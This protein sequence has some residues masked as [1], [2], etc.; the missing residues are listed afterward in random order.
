[1]QNKVGLYARRSQEATTGG[2]HVTQLLTFPDVTCHCSRDEAW[3]LSELGI[4]FSQ[5]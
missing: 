3:L 4:Q 2:P 1:M 5:G